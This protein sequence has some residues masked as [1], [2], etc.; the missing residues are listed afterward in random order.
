MLLE[1]DVAGG[2]NSPMDL[3]RVFDLL[4]EP[5]QVSRVFTADPMGQDRWCQVTGWSAAGP[6]PALAVLAED[7]G[8]GVILLIYG[9]DAGIRL[10]PADS[11]E[12][13][14]L[15]CANQWGEPC[16]M[17]DQNTHVERP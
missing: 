11:Q 6:C 4:T 12:E 15:G 14:G 10:K 16:L 9:G 17:L 7:S 8:D 13:W 1:I 5:V 3:N 2:D